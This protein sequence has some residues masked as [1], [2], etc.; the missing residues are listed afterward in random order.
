MAC[1]HN[2][3]QVIEY[4]DDDDDDDGKKERRKKYDAEKHIA[5]I[6]DN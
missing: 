1:L 3:I 2:H 6:I 5:Q 4:N